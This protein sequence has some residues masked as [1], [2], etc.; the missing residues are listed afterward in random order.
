M[1][2]SGKL[3]LLEKRQDSDYDVN[4]KENYIQNILP[5]I[6]TDFFI[7]EV[8]NL[9]LKHL[10]GGKV[11]IKKVLNK[12]DKD[13]YSSAAYGL[14]YIKNFEDNVYQD[15]VDEYDILASYTFF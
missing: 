9:Q 14:W 4:D 6:Q 12:L 11:S 7:G 15:D 3:R 13:R 5:F 1:I 10:D 2:E 8:S